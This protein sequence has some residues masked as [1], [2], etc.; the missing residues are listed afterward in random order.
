MIS[1]SNGFK[2]EVTAA[3]GKPHVRV[4][5][6]D[7]EVIIDTNRVSVTGLEKLPAVFETAAAMALRELEDYWT[8]R[9]RQDQLLESAR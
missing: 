7:G 4:S 9:R 5:F 6:R 3:D 8:E 1:H 2:L